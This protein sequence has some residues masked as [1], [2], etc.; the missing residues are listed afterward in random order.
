[1]II[2]VTR[3]FVQISSLSSLLIA[4]YAYQQ[5]KKNR[6]ELHPVLDRRQRRI[7]IAVVDVATTTSAHAPLI[8]VILVV[9]A[10][11]NDE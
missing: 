2:Q 4:R 8:L 6:R 11:S 9:Q 1:M 10:M 5:N 3:R 7:V